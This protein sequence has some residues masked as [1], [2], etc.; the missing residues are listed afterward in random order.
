MIDIYIVIKEYDE[1]LAKR[2]PWYS[3][4]KLIIDLNLLDKNVTVVNHID[5]VPEE[6]VGTVIKT[7][8]LSDLWSNNTGGYKLIY[9]M[10]FPAYGLG[11]FVRFSKKV[12][13]Q[14]WK[15][16]KR[17]FIFSLMPKFMLRKALAQADMTVTISDRSEEYLTQFTDTVQ[18]Y[19]FISDNWGGYSKELTNKTEHKTVG[20]FGPPFTT[21]YFDE[22]VEFFSWLDSEKLNFSKK[23]I[24]RIERDELK[25]ME[26]KYLSQFSNN[27]SF[28]IISGFLSRD[29]LAQQLCDIDVLILPFRI[30]MSE[31][32][33]VVLEALELNI[34][35]VTTKDSGIESLTRDMSNVLMLDKF[36]KK[37]YQEVVDFVH[38]TKPD[39]FE[40]IQ[41]RI[42]DSNQRALENVCQN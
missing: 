1:Q 26:D 34:P 19:P 6:F 17:I 16:L 23:I 8:G 30:V 13:H 7:F 24:T 40:K 42:N 5:E 32:P 2:Q 31:L 9:F 28:I 29:E 15:D 33:V 38:Q 41:K 39:S 27:P 35:I 4:K 18:Y 10:T 11:K 3:I 36:S 12:L 14:N 37:H 21:R 25:D 20:Y 22:V